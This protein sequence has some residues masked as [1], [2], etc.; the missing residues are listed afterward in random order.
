MNAPTEKS[1][2]RRPDYLA[3]WWNVF[4]WQAAEDRINRAKG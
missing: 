2:H 3:A 1:P 4:N